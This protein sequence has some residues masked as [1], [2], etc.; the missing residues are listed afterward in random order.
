MQRALWRLILSPLS[1]RGALALRRDPRRL[2]LVLPALFVGGCLSIGPGPPR[3]PDAATAELLRG[4]PSLTVIVSDL[5]MHLRDDTYRYDRARGADGRNI[6]AVALWRL[7]RLQ[8]ARGLPEQDWENVDVVIE[9][10]R[11]R[12]LERLRRYAAAVAA[13]DRVAA[14]ASVLEAPA[15]EAR[16]VISRF[17]RHSGPPRRPPPTPE[18]ELEL[19]EDRIAKWSDL[20]WEYRGT[21][22][23]PLAREEL[24]AWEML[25]VEWFA[26]RR[27]P[28]EATAACQR[29]LDR[30]QH[31][32][33]YAKHLIRLGDLYAEAARG[34]HLRFRAKAEPFDARAYQERIDRALAAYELASEQRKP[35]LRQEAQGKIGALLSYHRRVHTD[36]P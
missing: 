7:D 25:R 30:H 19:I 11:A 26:H 27:R 23:E 4:M 18:K 13:Y 34:Q 22:Y 1:R 33:L 35:A 6:F 29:L 28:E 15:L 20:A 10:A 16:E 3:Q 8:R 12:A 9:F 14:R 21:S 36:V 31:S 17:G 32:K 5:Q 24:E 2:A